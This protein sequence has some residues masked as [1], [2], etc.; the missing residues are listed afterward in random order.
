[1]SKCGNPDCCCSSSYFGHVT[2]GSGALDDYGFWEKPCLI[3][4]LDYK[5]RYPKE[6]VWPENEEQVKAAIEFQG[7][8]DNGKTRS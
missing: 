2:F 4:A 1:M 6:D 5:R 3:C 8:R 7:R